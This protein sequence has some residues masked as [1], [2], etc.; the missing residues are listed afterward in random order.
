[1]TSEQEKSLRWM[2]RYARLGK[3]EKM[4]ECISDFDGNWDVAVDSGYTVLGEA[5]M[6]SKSATVKAL[7][8]CGAKVSRIDIDPEGSSALMHA[9][10]VDCRECAEI[11]IDGGANPDQKNKDGRTALDIARSC[12]SVAVE[13]FL[14]SLA[15]DS[16]EP[17]DATRLKLFDAELADL[18]I[19][20]SNKALS[21]GVPGRIQASRPK[22]AIPHWYRLVLE[23][24]PFC[25]YRVYL[26]GP[27][28]RF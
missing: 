4:L 5:V 2:A 28:G 12:Q 11:L 23:E 17:L 15:A 13:A 21:C 6:A 27:G 25:R 19:E 26:S 14:S 7:L 1:M 20:L 10:R 8:D 3:I 16:D 24:I 22:S 9:A 18:L